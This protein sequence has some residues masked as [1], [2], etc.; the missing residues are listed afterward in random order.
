MPV[1]LISIPALMALGAV[2]AP[3]A[4]AAAIELNFAPREFRWL[5]L[6]ARR[7]R[8]FQTLTDGRAVLHYEPGLERSRDLPALLGD[9]RVE[10][11]RLENFFKLTLPR[12]PVVYL[13]HK[14]NDIRQLFGPEYGGVALL[15]ATAIVVAH[16]NAVSES[17]RHEFAHLYSA[18]WGAAM[19]PLVGE[20]LAVWLQ[21]S[22]NGEHID[23][24]ALPVLCESRLKLGS[25]LSREFFFSEPHRNASYI[26]AGSFTGFLLGQYGWKAYRELFRK[27]DGRR[28]AARFEEC[29]SV[30]LKEAERQWRY[31]VLLTS[32]WRPPT[33]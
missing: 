11:E 28:F 16:D 13:F 23:A 25:L 31:H 10:L 1:P 19:P 6:L 9:C 2:S 7:V 15:E 22:I 24:A 33:G 14:T 26:L 8:Q 12:T 27:Y 5:R 17:V 32:P 4:L 3:L 20:G 18:E 21:G 30:E 29:F